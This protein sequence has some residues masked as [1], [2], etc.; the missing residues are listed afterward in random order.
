MRRRH[1]SIAVPVLALQLLA[2]A[3]ALAANGEGTAGE[4]N[5]KVI[6]FFSLGLIVGITLFIT[7]AT[8][9]QGVLERRKE[10]RKAARMRGRTGW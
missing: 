6:T 4:T 9:V 3:P 8:I 1:F 5:D 2:A 7:V 10:S